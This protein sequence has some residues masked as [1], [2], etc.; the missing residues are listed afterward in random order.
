MLKWLLGA[1]VICL[2][3]AFLV[4]FLARQI[5][6]DS[7]LDRGGSWNYAEEICDS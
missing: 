1:V 2:A 7:C 5:A 4:K 3:I 6:I